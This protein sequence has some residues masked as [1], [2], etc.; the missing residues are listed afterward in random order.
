MLLVI[1]L[2]EVFI[3]MMKLVRTFFDEKGVEQGLAEVL[4]SLAITIGIIIFSFI[5]HLV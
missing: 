5:I 3:D 2:Q 1:L 4:A